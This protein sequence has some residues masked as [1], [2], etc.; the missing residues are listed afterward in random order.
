MFGLTAHSHP[1]EGH[2]KPFD[3]KFQI[4]KLSAR[5]SGQGSNASYPSDDGGKKDALHSSSSA[6][7]STNMAAYH[8]V[9][10]TT[11]EA[12]GSMSA[13]SLVGSSGLAASAS[14]IGVAE[15]A[16]KMLTDFFAMSN[17]AKMT[18]TT[19]TSSKYP[20]SEMQLNKN[21]QIYKSL[22]SDSLPRGSSL[23]ASDLRDQN[24]SM[25]N[26]P[27]PSLVSGRPTPN[28]TSIAMLQQ[29][30]TADKTAEKSPNHPSPMST[31]NIPTN[32]QVAFTSS[33]ASASSSSSLSNINH[34][35]MLPPAMPSP[36][37]AGASAVNSDAS[38]LKSSGHDASIDFSGH[39]YTKSDTQQHNYKLYDSRHHPATTTM[40]SHSHPN[41]RATSSPSVQVHIV[42]SPVPSPLVVI[43]SPRSSSSPC[44]TDDELM[45]EA[46]IGIGSK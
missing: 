13:M 23:S 28:S 34:H 46:L 19:N 16:S 45:D 10:G 7:P 36:T 31:M 44:I 5:S 43:P 41:Q 8:S 37:T 29:Y 33:V 24:F 15:G 18:G 21:L 2:K 22:S 25:S 27:T 14:G 26:P 39:L 30:A 11:N 35:S 38:S 42:K 17:F 4:P 3:S 40:S 32:H 20:V 12:P 9:A 6:P 1:S